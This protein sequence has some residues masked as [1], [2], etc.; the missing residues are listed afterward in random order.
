MKMKGNVTEIKYKENN[1]EETKERHRNIE[2]N[3]EV[4]IQWKRY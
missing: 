3:T 2:I 1:K 4:E